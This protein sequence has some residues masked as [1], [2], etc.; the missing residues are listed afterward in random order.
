M[1]VNYTHINEDDFTNACR[2]LDYITSKHVVDPSVEHP[3]TGISFPRHNNQAF[4]QTALNI[5]NKAAEEGTSFQKACLSTSGRKRSIK[6]L[7]T[8]LKDH[9]AFS[10]RV[11]ELALPQSD[12]DK[13]RGYQI[14]HPQTKFGRFIEIITL[15]PR[16]ALAA[17]AALVTLLFAGLVALPVDAR[18]DLNPKTPVV[19]RAADDKAKIEKDEKANDPP[20][21]GMDIAGVVC[22]NSPL[23]GTPALKRDGTG[24]DE[25]MKNMSIENP[26]RDELYRDSLKAEQNGEL[27]VFTYGSTL[28]PACYGDCHKLTENPT[29][30]LTVSTEEH[31][32]TMISPR[33]MLFLRNALKQLDPTGKIPVVKLHGSGSG[34]FQFLL[35]RQASGASRTFAVDYAESILGNAKETT[36]AQYATN[37]KIKGIFK[38]VFEVTGQRKVILVGHSMG[39]PVGLEIAR[40]IRN[41]NKAQPKAS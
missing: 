24:L 34:K 31:F 39:G 21:S 26:W 28:D 9:A 19:A 15:I 10:K 25:R 22:F 6:T 36:I 8:L 17:I 18:C 1:N 7:N 32:C 35:F 20:Y 30:N 3:F 27:N 12:A 16:I 14:A 13:V 2:I 11:K 38:K 40:N 5:L 41:Y 29:R 37:D 4:L 33:A 23:R